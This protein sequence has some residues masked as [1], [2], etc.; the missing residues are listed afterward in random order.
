[1]T[2]QHEWRSVVLDVGGVERLLAGLS[3]QGYELIGPTIRDRAI[4]YDR[5]G[6]VRDLPVGW[7][8]VQE[9]GGY[10]LERRPDRALF[11]YAVGPHSWK[12]YLFP[13]EERLWS[14]RRVSPADFEIE[15]TALQPPARAFIGVRACEL[16]AI[17]IQDRVFL[18]GRFVDEHYRARRQRIFTVAV[19]CTV[20][21]STCFCASMQTGPRAESGFDIA[22]TEVIEGERH[23]FRADAG[24]A[25]G[26]DRLAALA[27]PVAQAAESEAADRAVERTA[28]QMVRRIERIAQVPELLRENHEHPRWDELAERCLA[29]GNCTLVCPTCFCSTVEDVTDLSGERSERWRKWDSCFTGDFSYVHGGVVRESTRSRYR[30]W[31]THKLSTWHEQFGTSGCVGCGRCITWCP[32][33]IDLTEEIRVMQGDVEDAG[34]GGV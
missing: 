32:V 25:A 21:A 15:A 9:A 23:Y 11:G 28:A 3:A 34:E 19:Q 29:C 13:P 17:A 33:G 22:L 10:R 27:A 5:I 26:A 24:S 6:S 12:Q 8:D 18:G 16:H 2:A 4:V 31:L 30:Q 7:T 1:M 20:A 14:A